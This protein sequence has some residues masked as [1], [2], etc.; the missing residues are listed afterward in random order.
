[1]DPLHPIQ[2]QLILNL[3]ALLVAINQKLPMLNIYFP[4]TVRFNY[5]NFI[6]YYSEYLARINTPQQFNERAPILALAIQ[7]THDAIDQLINSCQQI[8]R[9]QIEISSLDIPPP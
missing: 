7:T 1:M 3:R 9:M 2:R 6:N 4:P 8:V 5:I